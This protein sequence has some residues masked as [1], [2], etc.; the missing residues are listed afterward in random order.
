MSLALVTSKIE[1]CHNLLLGARAGREVIGASGDLY[2]EIRQQTA[3][4]VVAH[5]VRGGHHIRCVLDRAA[6]PEAASRTGD[7]QVHEV[8]ELLEHP[9]FECSRFSDKEQFTLAELT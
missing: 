3:D 6:T 2:A 8:R 5:T 7:H 1:S 9:V 4:S